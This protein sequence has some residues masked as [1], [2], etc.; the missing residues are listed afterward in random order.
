MGNGIEWVY[1]DIEGDIE[2]VQAVSR[3]LKAKIHLY[4]A[5][6]DIGPPK[7]LPKSK[8]TGILFL[9]G[10]IDDLAVSRAR[11]F[12]QDNFK[13]PIRVAVGGIFNIQ[14]KYPNPPVRLISLYQR[15]DLFF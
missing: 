3:L 13:R 1:G 7:R 15:Q 9:N 6:D 12:S 4:G 11:C 5:G 2:F 10:T 14:T 8:M